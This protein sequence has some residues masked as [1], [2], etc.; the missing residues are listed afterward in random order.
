M[1]SAASHWQWSPGVSSLMGHGMHSC[2]PG[3]CASWNI[4]CLVVALNSISAATTGSHMHVHSV[5]PPLQSPHAFGAQSRTCD[6]VPCHMQA[7]GVYTFL[8]F[9]LCCFW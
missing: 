4:G 9:Y 6:G 3:R 2:A 8:A 5:V 7:A 1:A